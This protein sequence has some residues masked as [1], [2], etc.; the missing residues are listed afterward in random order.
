[1]TGY[2]SLLSHTTMLIAQGL[3]AF[4]RLAEAAGYCQEIID[5]GAAVG[6][7]VFYPAGHGC[8]GLASILLEWNDLARAEEYLDRGI[9]LCR[10]AGLDGVF[11]GHAFMARLRQARGDYA[12]A[13][14]ELGWLEQ[15]FQRKDFTVLVRQVSIRL[16]MDDSVGAGQ[17][18]MPLMMMLGAGPR[19]PLMVAEAFQV[20]LARIWVS[21]GETA[22]A[23]QLLDEL[24]T[25]AEAGSRTGRLAEVH[26]L[27]ALALRKQAGNN[28]P[29]DALASLARSLELGEP[30]GYVVLFLEAGPALVPLLAAVEQQPAIPARV[31]VYARKLLEA[32]ARVGQP[33]ASLPQ[34]AAPGGPGV[35]ERLAVQVEPEALA[36]PLSPRELEVLRLIASGDSNQAIA[37]KLFITVRTVKKHAGNIYGKL[38]AASRTQAVARARELGLVE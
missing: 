29:Q 8:I 17:F 18:A 1:M 10:Q 38:G 24:Q 5:L 23:M 22:R 20:T 35:L 13:L 19:L 14:E 21:Q 3:Y 30:A 11:T 25:V 4:G 36:E 34:P 33:A 6:Q 32:F 27:R 7:P 16:A 15:N 37:E 26:L 12:G 2:Y 28:I 31:K 9:E